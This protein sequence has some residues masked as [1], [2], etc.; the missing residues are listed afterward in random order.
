MKEMISTLKA[1]YKA[2]P[3]EFVM[4]TALLTGVAAVFC[5]AMILFA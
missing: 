1:S 2:N 4:S 5:L 3:K